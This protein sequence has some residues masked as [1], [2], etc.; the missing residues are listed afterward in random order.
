MQ[1]VGH[2]PKKAEFATPPYFPPS[3]WLEEGS[4]NEHFGHCGK[5]PPRHGSSIR[6]KDPGMVVPVR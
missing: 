5:A 2:V 6:Q 3:C 4:A 1:F